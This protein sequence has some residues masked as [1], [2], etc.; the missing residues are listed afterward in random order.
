MAIA[1]ALPGFNDLGRFV[2]PS[3]LSNLLHHVV[4]TVYIEPLFLYQAIILGFSSFGF[5]FV[6]VTFNMP[7]CVFAIFFSCS[8]MFWF[9]R[10]KRLSAIF[11]TS[12]LF[13]L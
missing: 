10:A 8:P 12:S 3:Y 9:Y 7:V 13:P 6:S 4:D 11:F 1:I 2:T 5:S